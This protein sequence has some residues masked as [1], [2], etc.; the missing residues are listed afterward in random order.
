[1]GEEVLKIF[2]VVVVGVVVHEGEGEGGEGVVFLVEGSVVGL[3]D[4]WVIGDEAD[5]IVDDVGEEDEEEECGSDEG[6]PGGDAIVFGHGYE[7]EDVD[8]PEEFEAEVGLLL[9]DDGTIPQ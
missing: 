6:L 5:E 2:S 9:V 1:M 4:G 3:D 7:A 8:F